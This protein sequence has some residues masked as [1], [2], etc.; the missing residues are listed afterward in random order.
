[1]KEYIRGFDVNRRIAIPKEILE[2]LKI[3]YEV[4]QMEISIVN[5]KI[6]L[7]KVYYGRR[8]KKSK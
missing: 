3:D 4:D 2:E 1:M 6:I 7:E 5:G 8:N